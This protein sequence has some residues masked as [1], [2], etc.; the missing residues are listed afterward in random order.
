MYLKIV[1][2]E[3]T[4]NT[5]FDNERIKK[6]SFTPEYDPTLKSYPACT[7]EATIFD[8]VN[9]ESYFV[10]YYVLLYGLQ[11]S[12]ST[13]YS[14]LVAGYYK[15]TEVKRNSEKLLYIKANSI[16]TELD[17]KQL[18][19]HFYNYEYKLPYAV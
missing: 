17:K 2:R 11:P 3:G 19:D 10:G 4:E 8:A 14:S 5:H 18:T 13:D 12:S 1:T 16:L 9:N 7:L 6:L 15:I